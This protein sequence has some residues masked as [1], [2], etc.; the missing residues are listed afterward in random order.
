M[1]LPEPYIPTF[2]ATTGCHSPSDNFESLTLLSD[3]QSEQINRRTTIEET[4]TKR[5]Q[6]IEHSTGFTD[7]ATEIVGIE[8]K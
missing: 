6:N 4:W 2:L 1:A 5:N 8:N 3:V 7:F